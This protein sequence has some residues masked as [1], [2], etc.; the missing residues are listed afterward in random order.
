MSAIVIR[1]DAS[2]SIGSGHVMRCLSLAGALRRLGRSVH[3][4]IAE[5]GP[6]LEQRI[7]GEGYHLTSLPVRDPGGA[8][9]LDQ[10]VGLARAAG[11]RVAVVDGYHFDEVYQR[12]L[13]EAVER[14]VQIDDLGEAVGVAD[15]V[16]N[17]SLHAEDETYRRRSRSGAKLLLGPRYALLRGEFRAA[18]ARA[19]RRGRRPPRLLVT[20][21]GADPVDM[22]ARVVAVL[23]GDRSAPPAT[24]VVGAA[25]R[26]LD[27]LRRAAHGVPQRLEL[28]VDEPRMAD[29]MLEAELAVAAGGG[30][31]WELCCLGV[32]SLLVAL[33]PNQ[34]PITARAALVG[35][36][37]DLGWHADVTEDRLAAE[38]GRLARDEARRAAMAERGRALVDGEGADR[39]AAAIAAE[40]E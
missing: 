34:L 23:A 17:H 7:R 33:A 32:P 24:V 6:A 28:R 13:R 11:A 29:L 31:A 9:D 27:R 18:R 21:G 14:L 26:H 12:G 35:V 20:M 2:A 5:A 4:A 3:F 39:V 8:A 30:T 25:Y 15:V 38:I 10:T 40:M 36:A 37:V 19:A 16:V 22:T 1:T